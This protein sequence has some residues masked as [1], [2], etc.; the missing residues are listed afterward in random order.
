MGHSL[1]AV[2]VSLRGVDVSTYV[3]DQHAVLRGSSR[4]PARLFCRTPLTSS[5]STLHSIANQFTTPCSENRA[6]KGPL[7]RFKH[8]PTYGIWTPQQAR[9]TNIW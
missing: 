2:P 4:H 8:S 9:D 5:I 1:F 7:L 3:Q 6:E